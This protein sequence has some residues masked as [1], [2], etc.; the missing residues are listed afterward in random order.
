MGR[1]CAKLFSSKS[2]H[3]LHWNN[4][5][6]TRQHTFDEEVGKGSH[7]PPLGIAR[8][9]MPRNRALLDLNMTPR[10]PLGIIPK[11]LGHLVHPSHVQLCGKVDPG[12]FVFRGHAA[13]AVGGVT[14][15]STVLGAHTEVFDVSEV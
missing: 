13:V 7:L 3:C 6:L 10:R 4:L 9:I 14:D 15:E 8:P 12:F 5:Q 1:L 2:W 11:N